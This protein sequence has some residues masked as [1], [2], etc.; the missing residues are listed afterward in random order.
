MID[1]NRAT[2]VELEAAGVSPALARVIALW[3]PYR[4]WDDLLLVSDVDDAA[5]ATLQN[6]GFE[7]VPAD[8]GGW[9]PPKPFKLS[10]GS[11]R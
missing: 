1:L 2:P 7:I 5:I 3:Q 10:A 4:S 9:A 8:D 11:R 6:E